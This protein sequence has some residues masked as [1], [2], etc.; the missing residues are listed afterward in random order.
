MTA[1]GAREAAPAAAT[2]FAAVPAAAAGGA[3]AAEA[4]LPPAAAADF[5]EAFLAAVF[6][7]AA[8]EPATAEAVAAVAVAAAAAVL[9]PETALAAAASVALATGVAEDVLGTES[10]GRPHIVLRA[11]RRHLAH[12]R[13]PPILDGWSPSGMRDR[14]RCPL[15]D[16]CGWCEGGTRNEGRSLPRGNRNGR[17]PHQKSSATVGEGGVR[18][19]FDQTLD[20]L[21]K[22]VD[23]LRWPE[24]NRMIPKSIASKMH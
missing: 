11:G 4:A 10:A 1:A 14:S 6:G 17:K 12:S 8:A 22:I 2:A 7:A 23:D 20:E 5:T 3:P 13:Q 9:F 21:V 24:G 15:E 16:S 19:L 18:D